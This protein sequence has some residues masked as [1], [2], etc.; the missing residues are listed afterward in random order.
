[1]LAS[2]AC[3]ARDCA[4]ALAE[5]ADATR[6][7]SKLRIAANGGVLLDRVRR[8]A[9]LDPPQPSM[10]GWAVALLT[11]VCGLAIG[12]FWA[13]PR[14]Q[15]AEPVPQQS[16]QLSGQTPTSGTLAKGATRRTVHG[17]VLDSRG[18]P[19]AGASIFSVDP[20]LPWPT[21]AEGKAWTVFGQADAA[22][23]LA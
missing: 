9:G 3:G 2:A 19:V 16:A 8:L 7:E 15:S 17:Q 1:D 11:V 23:V 10:A 13:T 4:Q 21:I 12:A 22:A 20:K 18:Q 5:L 14:G 6:G